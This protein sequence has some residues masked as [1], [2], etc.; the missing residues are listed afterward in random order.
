MPNAL[1]K[2]V[3]VA[4]APAIAMMPEREL[5]AQAHPASSPHAQYGSWGVDLAGAD[6]TIRPGANFFRYVNGGWL[7]RTE[8]PADKSAYGLRTAMSDLTERRLRELLETAARNASH[9]PTTVEGKVGAF[10]RSFLDSA[11]VERLGATSVSAT[12]SFCT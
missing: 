5:A 2:C 8:I 12:F 11:R 9:E 1:L 4:L 6:T 7:D 3:A 10:Y